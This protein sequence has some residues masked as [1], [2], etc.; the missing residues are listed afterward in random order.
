MKK[1]YS[2]ALA[3]IKQCTFGIFLSLALPMIKSAESQF[4][5]LSGG[6]SPSGNYYSQYLQ[7]KN[8]TDNLRKRFGF[9]AVDVAFGA[10]NRSDIPPLIAD[11]HRTFVE[12]TDE[13]EE[14]YIK[15]E[16]GNIDENHE[17]TK[18]NVLNMLTQQ[19]QKNRPLYLL[20][21]D[22]GMPNASVSNLK[23]KYS[24]NCINLWQFNASINNWKSYEQGCLSVT[25]LES[26]IKK[27]PSSP[28]IYGMSQ[29]FS[30]GFHQMTVKT[31]A[32]GLVTV[33]PKIC[34][35]SA[36]TDDL[37]ASGCTANVDGP[38]YAG[39]ERF[40]TKY[41]ISKDFI[42]GAPTG[43][44][45]PINLYQAHLL[46]MLEDATN[47]IPLSS[48]D[49]YLLEVAKSLDAWGSSKNFSSQTSRE[50]LDVLIK[51]YSLTSS[52]APLDAPASSRS[53]FQS[54]QS[55]LKKLENLLASHY[56]NTLRPMNLDLGTLKNELIEIS[57]MKSK[58]NEKYN[59]I[60]AEV[61]PMRVELN[62]RWSDLFEN[63]HTRAMLGLSQEEQELE[64]LL[65]K[66]NGID[67]RPNKTINYLLAYIAIENPAKE[68]QLSKYL[69]I[70]IQK[71]WSYFDPL[72]GPQMNEKMNS[73]NDINRK[74]EEL[75]IR[76]SIT[77]RIF[78]ART[79]QGILGASIETKSHLILKNYL[80]L[81]SCESTP[82]PKDN[83]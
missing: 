34:G 16:V 41:I 56:P 27:I 61:N 22:H 11:V 8:L 33:N 62:Q 45:K 73:L 57:K 12:K 39:Y 70:R 43:N 72:I 82:F 71:F 32:K 7:T 49:Y 68:R 17:A 54:Q 26:M 81:R 35:F 36:T 19:S 14:E 15:M 37:I 48:S 31:N 46:A 76:Y 5:V 13:G 79:I 24:N 18:E 9:Q 67:F 50:K 83:N 4:V 65:L 75:E 53:V 28:V 47:D 21:S 55:I 59:L 29:C 30:G 40:F 44:P 63:I 78:S 20:V 64:N 69:N 6:G 80:A 60:S 2:S 10:G 77:R 25:E 51:R 23:N 42:T 38:H 74:Y 1:I 58:L 66:K 52:R 3:L